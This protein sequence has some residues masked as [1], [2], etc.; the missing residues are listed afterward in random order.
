MWIKHISVYSDLFSSPVWCRFRMEETWLT[1]Y[2]S[3]KPLE[4]NILFCTSPH[5]FVCMS[6][7]P[8]VI[9]RK[10]RFSGFCNALGSRPL[11]ITV[12]ISKGTQFL[13][14]HLHKSIYTICSDIRTYFALSAN[15][16]KTVYLRI[17]RGLVPLTS[18]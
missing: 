13:S 18:K 3:G 15:L 16:S 2:T 8:L 10:Y 5:I 11:L 6:N 1:T 17:A 12:L 7:R 14:L 9:Y 4:V